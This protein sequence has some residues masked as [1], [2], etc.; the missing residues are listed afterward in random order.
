[1]SSSCSRIADAGGVPPHPHG[2]C[3]PSFRRLPCRCL[4]EGG[5]VA[6]E[7][8]GASAAGRL[9]GVR[10]RSPCVCKS[11]NRATDQCEQRIHHQ[12]ILVRPCDQATFARPDSAIG[13]AS[14]LSRVRF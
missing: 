10:G 11:E 12:N 14:E 2:G 5:S 3:M 4:P 13:R 8:G 6:T 1:M 7:G 9:L